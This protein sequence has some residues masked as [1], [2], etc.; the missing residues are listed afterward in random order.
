MSDKLSMND[1]AGKTMVERIKKERLSDRVVQ[2]IQQLIHEEKFNPGDKFYSENAL[3]E[4]LGVSRSS[5]REAIRSLETEGWITVRHG[6]G[7]FI[8]STSDRRGEGFLNWLKS[9]KDMMLEHFEVRLMLDPK[10]AAYA[11]KNATSEEISDLW[12]ICQEF[13][14]KLLVADVDSLIRV[15][16][17]F[18]FSVAR[19][20]KNKTLYILMKTMAKSLPVGWISSLNVPGRAERTIQEHC[21]VVEAIAAKDQKAAEKAMITHLKNA[22]AEIGAYLENQ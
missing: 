18:H 19:C 14:E 10:A 17:R 5:I 13:K 4:R 16:E 6:K 22:M 2:I 21:A 9:N 7:S 11:A 3:V 8:V 1:K 20:T 15:D 12:K